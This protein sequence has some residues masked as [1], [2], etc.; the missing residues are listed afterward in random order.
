MKPSSAIHE[1]KR[2]YFDAWKWINDYWSLFVLIDVGIGRYIVK[3]FK[4]IK[5]LRWLCHSL[6]H[7]SVDRW[8]IHLDVV[9][10][11]DIHI[12]V[13][14]KGNIWQNCRTVVTYVDWLYIYV[15]YIF[16]SNTH[17]YGNQSGNAVSNL[18]Y[19]LLLYWRVILMTVDKTLFW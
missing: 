12:L 11:F 2:V 17:V 6:S 13:S 4:W 5:T 15:I 9:L 1:W 10:C 7:S 19:W 8:V 16:V 18:W 3:H 14:P